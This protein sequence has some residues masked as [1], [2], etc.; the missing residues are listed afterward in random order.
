MHH[1]YARK[2]RREIG[3]AKFLL[4]KNC[5]STVKVEVASRKLGCKL[6]AE[7]LWLL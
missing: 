7:K 4:G 5:S 2:E 3:I 6:G 1:Q